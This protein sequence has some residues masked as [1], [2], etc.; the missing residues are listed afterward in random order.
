MFTKLFINNNFGL[1]I[2]NG[3]NCLKRNLI[4]NSNKL[5]LTNL[6][7]LKRSIYTS[8]NSY[9]ILNS[10]LNL[11]PHSISKNLSCSILIN[12]RFNSTKTI[13]QNKQ[14]NNNDSDESKTEN[15]KKQRTSYQEIKKLFRLAKSEIPLMSVAFICLCLSSAVSMIFPSV[16]GKVIDSTKESIQLDENGEPDPLKTTENQLFEVGSLKVTSFQFY[17]GLSCIF[18]VGALANFSRIVLLRKVG[19]RLMAKLRLRILKK[20]L[21][22]DGKFWDVH[23]TGDLISRLVNDSTVVARSVTQNVSDGL[24][25]TISGFVGATMMLFISVKLTGYMILMFPFLIFVAL[26]FGRRIK[27]ISKDIQTQLGSLTKVVEEQ[28][29]L[30]KTVQSFNNEVREVG[31]FKTEV[32]KL[33]DLSVK[34]GLLNGYFYASTGFFGNT[35]IILLLTLGTYMV[36]TGELSVGD[37]SSFMMYTIYTGSS[38]FSLSNFYSELMKGVGASGRIFE[39]IDL[40]PAIIPTKGEKIDD[41][42]GDIVFEDI[43]FNYPTRENHKV[44]QNLNLTIKEGEHVCLVGPSGCGKSTVTQLLLR[45]YEP[46]SGDILING[47]KLNDMSLAHFRKQIGYVEQEPMLFS[48]TLRE[49]LTYGKRNATDS[50]IDEVCQLANCTEFINNFPDKLDTIIGPKGAQL[51]GGQKQR[52]ALARSLLCNPKILILDEATSALDTQ[53]EK[54]I[55]KTLIDRQINNLT[56]ISI[57]HRLSTIKMSDT[58]VVFNT[59][60]EIIE[61][62]EFTKLISNPDS[63]LNKLL[64]KSDGEDDTESD[65]TK[66]EEEEEE[67]IENEK[68]KE[69]SKT[70]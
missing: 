1:V 6:I 10:K 15:D 11:T 9:N 42:R 32:V 3:S 56:T 66:K 62:D 35:A 70:N 69:T 26:V 25:A 24:R 14:N 31:K 45:Y 16:L 8:N 41:I 21:Y 29:N 39:L 20:I 13:S 34:E 49:N 17:A 48:G 5:N 43:N 52:I 28:F 36:R 33:Y 59:N 63:H 30:T 2:N 40:E 54:A 44:F 57:A 61:K 23:K 47:H 19:E 38:V 27:S 46:Q 68:E 50:E 51:S 65:L 7:S 60:G 18:L 64:K 58:I 4:I 53:S 12:K 22:Q 37:L 67:E 55:H